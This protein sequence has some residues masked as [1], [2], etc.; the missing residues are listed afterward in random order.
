MSTLVRKKNYVMRTL[1]FDIIAE[2]YFNQLYINQS[3]IRII[4]LM[5]SEILKLIK[6]I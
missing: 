5:N 2:K 1:S 3:K 4:F 6:F